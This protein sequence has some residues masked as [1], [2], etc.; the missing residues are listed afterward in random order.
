MGESL[1]NLTTMVRDILAEPTAARFSQAHI[2]AALQAGLYDVAWRLP[3][4]SAMNLRRQK[5]QVTVVATDNYALPVDF[6]L[7]RG[8]MYCALDT[9]PCTIINDLRMLAGYKNNY[10]LTPSLL[11]GP[12]VWIQENSLSWNINVDPAPEAVGQLIYIY[13]AIPAV[14]S[15]QQVSQ[16][17]PSCDEPV[18]VYAAWKLK[19]G[20]DDAD[21]S[22]LRQLYKASLVRIGASMEGIP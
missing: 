10:L 5:T 8:I 14:I 15:T 13:R 20:R 7:E 11:D 19:A 4:D 17:P 21:A 6:M 2:T 9:I 12:I 16:L 3:D 22:G 1:A 18:S